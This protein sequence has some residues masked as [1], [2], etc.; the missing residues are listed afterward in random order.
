[1]HAFLEAFSRFNNYSWH[2]MWTKILIRDCTRMWLHIEWKKCSGDKIRRACKARKQLVVNCA[3]WWWEVL[4]FGSIGW[5]NQESYAFHL[6]PVMLKLLLC[7]HV[8]ILYHVTE[9]SFAH[10]EKW[11]WRHCCQ[12]RPSCRSLL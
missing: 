4:P 8:G 11:A 12:F 3:L 10:S 2:E 9:V 5:K 7:S 6:N 1:M